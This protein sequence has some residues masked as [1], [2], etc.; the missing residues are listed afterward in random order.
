MKVLFSGSFKFFDEMKRL[1]ED[2]EKAGFECILPRFALGDFSA[3]EIEKI[4]EKRRKEMV[5]TKRN[6]RKL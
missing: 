6:L 5:W 1:K 4:K 3:K 2:L